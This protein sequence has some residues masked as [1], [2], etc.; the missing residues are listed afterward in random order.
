M[1][2]EPGADWQFDV[3]TSGSKRLPPHSRYVEALTH[4]GYSFEAAVADLVDNSIDAGA[5]KVVIS[6]LRDEDRL[7]SLLIVDDGRG[8][9]ESGLDTAMTV[10][11]QQHYAADALGKFGT[12]LK[13][14]SMS[15]ADALTVISRTKRSPSAGRRWLTAHARDD[16]RCD[17]VEASYC[18]D[19]VDR[20]DGV[21][22]WHGT[23][24]RWDKVR[25]FETI[26]S[27]QTDRFLNEAIE[28]LETQLGLY[29]HR[30]LAR[31]DFHIDIV[32]EDVRTREELDHRGVLPIDPFGY[33]VPGKAGFPRVFTAPIEGTGDLRITTHIWPAKS[34]LVG[35]RG[36]GALADRQGFYFYRNNR[37]VQP[38]GWN[39][40]RLPES[41]HN[42]ARIAVD[43]PADDDVFKLTVK[44]DGVEAGPAFKRGLEK[45]ADDQ[46]RT[47]A[48]YLRDAENTYRDA[49][50]RSEPKRPSVVP[51]GKGFEPGLRRTLR[52]ELPQE[53]HEDP[54]DFRWSALPDG[55]FFEID[56]DERTVRLNQDY[57]TVFNG[58]KSG[59]NDAPALKSLLYLMLEKNF[60]LGR[61]SAQRDDEMALWNSVLLSAARCELAR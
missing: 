41:H 17:I 22:G 44:K 8:M 20:Y 25:A 46:G 47:F 51:P 50:R 33:R 60:R 59:L 26:E 35:Y 18:Q 48:D 24:V 19:L 23:I 58:G 5:T 13:A 32:V 36:I 28:K 45:A 2:Y 38:G 10:G 12:G 21:I 54:I 3:P 61:S 15:H 29:L 30:F 49:A 31:D 37:L 56:R 39:G 43:L 16:H 1:P 6:L 55:V 57:R 53:P 27:R 4:Q 14:A 11:G 52:E 7:V 42:L 34:P 40:Y 9:D